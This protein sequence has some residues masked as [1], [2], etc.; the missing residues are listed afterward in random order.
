MRT[1]SLSTEA[2]CPFVDAEDARCD[3][4]FKLGRLDEA[5]RECFGDYRL[6][7]HYRRLNVAQPL[8]IVTMTAYGRSLQP[9][10]A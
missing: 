5:L 2:A 9:V 6:C 7:R 4:H 10:G 3:S 1:A 8:S